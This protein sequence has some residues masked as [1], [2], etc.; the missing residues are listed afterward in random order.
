MKWQPKGFWN[1]LRDFAISYG[2]FEAMY[3]LKQGYVSFSQLSFSMQ[4]WSG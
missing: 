2:M 3:F 4:A 1:L